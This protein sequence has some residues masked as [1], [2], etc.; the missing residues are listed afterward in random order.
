MT[1]HIINCTPRWE[2]LIPLFCEWIKD[3]TPDQ[4]KIAKEN[5]LK[6]AKFADEQ[7]EK[8]GVYD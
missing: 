7:N 3:G 6:L 1:K 5:L 8:D 2:N 4:R